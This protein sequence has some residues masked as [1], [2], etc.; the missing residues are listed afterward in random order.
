VSDSSKSTEPSLASIDDVRGLLSG[1]FEHSPAAFQI[2]RADGHCLL[3]NP[4]F[5]ELFG[6]S[7]PPEYNVLKDD[8][9]EAQGFLELVRRAF[10]GETLRVPPHWHDPR[11]LRQVEVQEG[12]RVGVEAT[13]FPLRDAAGEIQY[14]PA[15]YLAGSQ[16]RAAGQFSHAARR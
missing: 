2:Y 4:A 14:I 16:R 1:L 8:L 3:V 12:R 9:L 15:G 11:E 7:P 6:G 10:G 5:R 13:L